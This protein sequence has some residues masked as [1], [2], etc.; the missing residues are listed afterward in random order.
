MLSPGVNR[1]EAG[2]M[3]VMGGGGGGSPTYIVL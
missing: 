1:C 2:V 3:G